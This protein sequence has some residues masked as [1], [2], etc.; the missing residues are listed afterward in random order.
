MADE[1]TAVAERIRSAFASRDFDSFGE[2]LAEDARWG[3]DD[4]CRNR[5]DVLATYRGLVDQGVTGDVTETA[6]GPG[7]VMC[8]LR[9]DWSGG[10]DRSGPT[11]LF[12]VFLVRDGRIVEIRGYDDRESALEAIRT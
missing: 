3:D 11:T 6:T 7:G 9:V 4:R 5:R 1:M 2:L 12:Q 10:A 8:E